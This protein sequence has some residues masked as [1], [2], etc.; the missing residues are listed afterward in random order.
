M[1]G[2]RSIAIAP[3]RANSEAAIGSGEQSHERRRHAQARAAHAIGVPMARTTVT[4]ATPG[5]RTGVPVDA[6]RVH[7][8]RG[9]AVCHSFRR[10]CR[11][12]YCYHRSAPVRPKPVHSSLA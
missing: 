3:F 8:P 4:Y 12:L 11:R 1:A 9:D 2:P 7:C 10:D 6:T 5:R